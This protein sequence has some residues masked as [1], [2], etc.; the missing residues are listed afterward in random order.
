MEKVFEALEV[1]GDTVIDGYTPLKEDKELKQYYKTLYQAITELQAIKEANP[2]EALKCL[3]KVIRDFNET[4]TGMN[5]LGEVVVGNELVYFH[6]KELETIEQSLQKAQ[7]QD[8]NYKNI[9]LPFFD[10]LSQLLGTN[11]IDEMMDKIKE[12][13]GSKAVLKAIVGKEEMK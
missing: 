1:V 4:T 2:S 6:K 13:V 11:D 9:V 12:L 8:F 5:G 10:E 7:E 3:D